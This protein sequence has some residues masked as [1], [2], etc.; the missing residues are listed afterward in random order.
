MGGVSGSLRSGGVAVPA[1]SALEL[2]VRAPG[3]AP[4]VRGGSVAP[5]AVRNQVR[6][7]PLL[8]SLPIL[9]KCAG[10]FLTATAWLVFLLGMA[11]LLVA[12]VHNQAGELGLG[13]SA[14]MSGTKLCLGSFLLAACGV[15]QWVMAVRKLQPAR[16]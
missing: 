3:L 14:T 4:A 16:S 10:I 11:Y 1:R 5:F 15:P 2:S 12:A 6:R 7:A 13:L 9:Q 8:P